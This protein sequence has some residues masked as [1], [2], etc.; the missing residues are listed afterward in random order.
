MNTSTFG[1]KGEFS[2]MGGDYSSDA[3]GMLGAWTR[4][5]AFGAFHARRK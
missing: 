4:G 5:D 3:Y 2:F 1:L